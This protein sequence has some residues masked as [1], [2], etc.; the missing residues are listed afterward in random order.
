MPHVLCLRPI[1]EDAIA[2]MRA[3][4]G[5]TVEVLE[6]VTPETLAARIAEADAITVRITRIDAGVL[7]HAPKLR[8]VSSVSPGTALSGM[9]RAVRSWSES[10]GDRRKVSFAVHVASQKST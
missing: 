5:V 8:I 4:P 6:P 1:H 3:T 9:R 2:L 10:G 7:A